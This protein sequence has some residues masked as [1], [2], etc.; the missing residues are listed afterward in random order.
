MTRAADRP[1]RS[2]ASASGDTDLD[3]A[4]LARLEDVATMACHGV[5]GCDA[6]A[7]SICLPGGVMTAAATTDAARRLVAVQYDAGEGPCLRAL[8]E[9]V[10]VHVDDLTTDPRWPSV[11]PAARAAGLRGVLSVPLRSGG[12][13]VGVLNL[14]SRRAG[15]FDPWSEHVAE[16]LARQAAG[17]VHDVELLRRSGAAST[18]HQRIS[19]ALQRDLLPVVPAVPGIS[20]AARHLAAEH[21]AEVGGDWYDVF[22]LPDRAIGL[23]V[24]DVMGHDIA[25]ASA[26]GQLRSVLRSYAYDSDSPADVLDRLDRLAQG[27]D[28]ALATAVYGTLVLHADGARL[29]FSNAGHVPPLLRLPDG[30]VRQLVDGASWLIGV[31]SRLGPRSAASTELPPGATLLLYTD[32]LVERHRHHL[33][34]GIDRLCRVLSGPLP[35]DAPD[36]LCDRVLDA[37]ADGGYVDDLALLA[38]RID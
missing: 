26:M 36:A 27:F 13:L 34:E 8:Q 31:P 18:T 14:H 20:C 23:A 33:D 11:G 24:G 10:I 19:Q 37:M 29:R 2:G 7:I 3:G 35:D 38:L 9:G 15:A 1:H 5:P 16:V 17:A 28:L 6:A 4:L 12:A 21:R 25:A 22:P 30:Q 32:G